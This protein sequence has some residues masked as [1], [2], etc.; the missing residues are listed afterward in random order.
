MIRRLSSTRSLTSR[1]AYFFV[2]ISVAMG[3]VTFIVFSVALH[4]SEDR[5]GERRILLDK[6]I[7]ID[8]FIAGEEGKIKIDV[9]TT[10]YNDVLLLPESYRRYLENEDRFLG[11]I[12]FD[13]YPDSRMVYKGYYTLNGQVKD[14]V[15]LST[16][17]NVEFSLEEVVYSGIIVVFIVSLLMFLFGTLLYRLSIRLIEPLN[18][19]AD[20]LAHQT[21]NSE[22]AFTI[23]NEA[24]EEFQ[25]LT[26][27]LNQY[28]TDLNL[29]LKREQAFARYASHELRTPLTV[30]KGAGTLLARTEQPEF[31]QRQITRIKNATNQM[32]TMVDALLGLVRYERNTED[33]PL[34]IITENELHSI[35]I[36]NSS[37]A[38]EKDLNINLV[39]DALPHVQ[40]TQPVMNMII[41][42]LIRNAIA[43][44]A[45]GEISIHVTDKMIEITDDGPGLNNQPNQDGHGL[46]LLIVDDLSR[47]YQWR[48][49]LYNHATRGCV[50]SITF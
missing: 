38:M 15:L 45:E 8:R 10:A 25:V 48:F 47:R 14:V 33:T 43:A 9:L 42:N 35:V 34:R 21:G 41:G 16:I 24:A 30:L 2:G 1:L 32:S 3:F 28:R 5:V 4:W 40:A 29:A 31:N 26:Q 44:S 27:R 11:E 46:G 6:D 12:E 22:S 7:A 37:Q 23:S 39:I 18:G 36:D 50:A 49:R 20:Q 19:I 17:D 13:H